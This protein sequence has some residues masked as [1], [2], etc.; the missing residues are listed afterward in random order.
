MSINK[1]K[2]VFDKLLGTEVKA[3]LL[4]FFHRNPSFIGTI[5][6]LALKINRRV[7]EVEDAVKDFVKLGLLNEVKHYSFNPEADKNIQE[8]ILEDLTKDESESTL[9]LVKDIEKIN[10]EVLDMLLQDGFPPSGLILILADPGSGKS[11]LVTQILCVKVAAGKKG[12]FITLDKFPDEV[13]EFMLEL[14]FNPSLFERENKLVF[15]DCYSIQVGVKS[16]E[17]YSEDPLN[18]SNLSI[19]ISKVLKEL[20]SPI[21]IFDSLSTLLQKGGIR[22]SLEFLRSLSG[23]IKDSKALCFITLN[24]KAFHP[25]ILAACEE[26]ADGVIEMKIEEIEGKVENYIRIFKMLR[27]RH[28]RSWLPYIIDPEKGLLPKT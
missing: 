2:I 12:V 16:K 6:E 11:F 8:L 24:R 25:A 10:I 21:V 19:V 28:L 27:R 5:D 13:R 23:K 14:G 9:E 4:I 22:S 15:I 1:H 17:K 20:S 7:E 3:E 18:F 26:I